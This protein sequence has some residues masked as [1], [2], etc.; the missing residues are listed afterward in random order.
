MLH[1]CASVGGSG[2]STSK[3]VMSACVAM[4]SAAV[5]CLNCA[6]GGATLL[7]SCADAPGP[8]A[9]LRGPCRQDVTR[10]PQLAFSLVLCL[11]S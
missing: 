4:S 10:G 5:F 2:Q 7:S 8:A 3:K 11:A 6:S 1:A 9:L